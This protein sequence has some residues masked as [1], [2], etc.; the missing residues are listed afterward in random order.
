M[1]GFTHVVNE[2]WTGHINHVEPCPRLFHK[3]KKTGKKLRAW[4]KSLFAKTKGQLHMA[5]EIILRLD[6]AQEN[7][8]LGND[9][10]DLRARLKWALS[11]WWLLRKQ[12]NSK[13][14]ELPTSRRVTQT[15]GTSTF[16]WM[17]GG[18]K[19]TSTV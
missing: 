3:L 6:M 17:P 12:R 5:L 10:R 19:I 15:V 7:W 4:S 16:V 8:A 13:L 1:L 18:E 14:Q 2:A 9:E 11:G